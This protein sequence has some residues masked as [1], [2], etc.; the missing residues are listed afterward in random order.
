M[1][2]NTTFLLMAQYGGKAIIPLEDVRRDYFSHL[3]LE[4]MHRKLC[5][6]QIALPVVRI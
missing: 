1:P 2:L 5:S 6:G 3:T 4:T